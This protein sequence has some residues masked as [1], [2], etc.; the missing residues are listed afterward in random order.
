MNNTPA[1]KKRVIVESPYKGDV[2]L[3]KGYARLAM[4]D[5]IFRGEAPFASHLLYT[6]MLDDNDTEERML[7][8]TLGFAWRQ[9]AHLVAFY[10]DLGMSDGMRLSQESLISS[11]FGRKIPFVERRINRDDL[12]KLLNTK[13]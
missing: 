1:T 7:G 9:V 3:N 11:S 8:I 6:Q 4:L 13:S 5:S 10:V 12:T 2:R